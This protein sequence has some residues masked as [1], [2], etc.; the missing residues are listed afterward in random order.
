MQVHCVIGFL[1]F[2][3]F[4]ALVTAAPSESK[5]F[6]LAS[7]AIP[8]E[9][10]WRGR[11]GQVAESAEWLRQYLISVK[12]DFRDNL[13]AVANN[14]DFQRAVILLRNPAIIAG[15]SPEDLA[16]AI[17]R[18]PASQYRSILVGI[19]N[20]IWSTDPRVV[21]AYQVA[22]ARKDPLAVRDIHEPA[23]SK[24]WSAEFVEL[25]V[26]IVETR[27][28]NRPPWLDEY[29]MDLLDRHYADWA[30]KK[31][32]ISPRLFRAVTGQLNTR[33]PFLWKA[34]VRMLAFTRD[35]MA[36]SLLR[37]YLQNQTLV[38]NAAMESSGQFV[39][40]RMCDFAHDAILHVLGQ[41]GE[42]GTLQSGIRKVRDSDRVD[43]YWPE[44]DRQ[45]AAL[46]Q[47]LATR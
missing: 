5:E 30:G 21:A 7:R 35:A 19:L 17:F 10:I 15:L 40:T 4:A 16:S 12:L 26:A 37:P 23:S 33:D 27:T 45:N 13:T 41:S 47:D 11:G 22:L 42:Y 28:A 32:A 29:S 9:F 38:N 44:W 36:I 24:I 39:S 8:V 34:Q 14:T 2:A 3:G 20:E 25:L 18:Q 43:E 6:I 31:E 46:A 1:C